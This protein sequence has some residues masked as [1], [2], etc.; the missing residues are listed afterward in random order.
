MKAPFLVSRYFIVIV[1]NGSEIIGAEYLEV[2][3]LG[4]IRFNY[5]EGDTPAVCPSEGRVSGHYN[6]VCVS[7]VI[8]HRAGRPKNAGIR[9]AV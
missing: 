4:L 1:L 6:T 8:V 3:V 2:E 9:L 7:A 5:V